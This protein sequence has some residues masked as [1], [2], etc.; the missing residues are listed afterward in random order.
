[1]SQNNDLGDCPS[2]VYQLVVIYGVGRPRYFIVEKR[3]VQVP[4]LTIRVDAHY[5]CYNFF[6]VICDYFKHI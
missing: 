3:V 2:L 1:M 6:A 5:D 4:I